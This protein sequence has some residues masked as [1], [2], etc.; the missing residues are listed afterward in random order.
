L[1]QSSNIFYLVMKMHYHSTNN[2]D[3]FNIGLAGKNKAGFTLL[4][5]LIYVAI[6]SL[7]LLLVS[8]FIFYLTLSNSQSRADREVGENA[9]RVLEQI[10]YE[11]NGAKSIYTPTTSAS[12]LSL[13]TVN[14]LPDGESTTYV[15]FFICGTQ[16]CLKKES[17]NPI[18]LTSDNVQVDLLEFIQVSTNGSQSI[19]INLTVKSKSIINNFQP[20]IDI[21]S[22]A[23]LRS[24]Q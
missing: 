8:S 20:S 14:Y 16:V 21:T 2:K 1:V 18:P 5:V 19:K 17:Q 7:V 13:E 11:I 23:S 4:E 12:Q 6:L 9:R 15:D 3:R 22:T 24:Y 10:T